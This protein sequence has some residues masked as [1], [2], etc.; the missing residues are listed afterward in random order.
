[1]NNYV[2]APDSEDKFV[3]LL[4]S[5]KTVHLKSVSSI[6]PVKL[7]ERLKDK[8]AASEGVFESDTRLIT[9]A[10]LNEDL[11]PMWDADFR[12]PTGNTGLLFWIEGLMK[13]LP[14]IKC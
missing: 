4:L 13:E 2:P 6:L 12:E 14:L 7:I 5:G 8:I 1:M 3:E 9:Q 11:S 10:V